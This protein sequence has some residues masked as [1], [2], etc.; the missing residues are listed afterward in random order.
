MLKFCIIFV[1]ILTSVIFANYKFSK[2]VRI[3]AFSELEE[4]KEA[5]IAIV[6]M[7]IAIISWALYFTLF[8]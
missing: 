1:A 8:V 7:F 4:P 6:T 2:A 5:K 3:I